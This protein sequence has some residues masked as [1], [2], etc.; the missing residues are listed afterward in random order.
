MFYIGTV[1][2]RH[3]QASIGSKVFGHAHGAQGSVVAGGARGRFIP[4]TGQAGVGPRAFH[5]GCGRG[6]VWNVPVIVFVS[7]CGPRWFCCVCGLASSA[8]RA[9]DTVP[10]C[11]VFLVC[12]VQVFG[13]FASAPRWQFTPGTFFVGYFF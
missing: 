2:A 10:R 3:A 4:R 7:E 6:T 9:E 8:G 1:V 13:F 5:E 11:R 12:I